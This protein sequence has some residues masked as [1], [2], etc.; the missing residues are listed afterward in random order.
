MIKNYNIVVN[1]ENYEVSVEEIGVS[2]PSPR[3]VQTSAPAPVAP[4]QAAAPKPAAPVASGSDTV[5][6][7]M[8]GT[9]IDV[10]AKE[11]DK[12][13]QGDVLCILE[14]MKM[15]NEIMAGADGVV[16][17]VKVS[18]GSSVSSGDVL[19]TLK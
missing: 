4:R 11:G 5:V 12:V 10:K 6:A 16:A 8:P 14:A 7:P 9:I 19:V 2:A 1:G 18:K 13:K 3:P 15:E 17:S